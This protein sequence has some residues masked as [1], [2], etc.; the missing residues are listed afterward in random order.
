MG[1]GGEKCFLFVIYP[2]SALNDFTTYFKNDYIILLGR[3]LNYTNLFEIA[4]VSFQDIY[5]STHDKISKIILVVYENMEICFS[6]M[7]ADS[8]NASSHFLVTDF[9][10]E[11][12]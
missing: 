12:L 9:V 5:I 4:I 1:G 2:S 10:T 3:K 6:K 11:L 7:M 8:R